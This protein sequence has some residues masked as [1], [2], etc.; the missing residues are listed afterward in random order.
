[1]TMRLVELSLQGFRAYLAQ[2]SF[3]LRPGKSLAVFAPNAKGKSSL[4]DAIEVFFSESGTLK[5]LGQKKSD[6]KAG[7]EA[8]DH[9]AAETKRSLRLYGS[10]SAIRRVLNIAQSV[11]LSAPRLIAPQLHHLSWLAASTTSSF[12]DTNYG[13]SWK[14]TPQRSG[15]PKFRIGLD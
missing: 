6:T 2:K 9:V 5:R 15:I 10:P 11:W 12:G 3:D 13:R 14:C 7:P 8:L 4:I 1:M